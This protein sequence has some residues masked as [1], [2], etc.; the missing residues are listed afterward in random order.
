MRIVDAEPQLIKD[1]IGEIEVAATRENPW[2]TVHVG[3]HPVVGKVVVI[4]GKEGG[5]LIVE[6]DE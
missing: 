3:R 2:L 1:F 5:S 6:V 4:E